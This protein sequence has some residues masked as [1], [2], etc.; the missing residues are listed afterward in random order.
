MKKKHI[1]T[2]VESLKRVVDKSLW[3]IYE[4]LNQE[5]FAWVKT[6]IKL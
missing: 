1:R 2:Y 3:S 6:K 4:K 5:F